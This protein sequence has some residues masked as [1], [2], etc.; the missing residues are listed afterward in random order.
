[1][2]TCKL[3]RSRVP[4]ATVGVLVGSDEGREVSNLSSVLEG[5]AVGDEEGIVDGTV[6][7]MLEGTVEGTLDGHD[8]GFP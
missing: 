7:G 2:A 1:M 8:E 4:T 5:C 3:L 6:D